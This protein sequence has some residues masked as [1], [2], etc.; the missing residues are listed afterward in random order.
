MDETVTTILDGGMGQEL[1]RRA[2]RPP[3]PLWSSRVLLDEPRL[4][5][6][7]HRDYIDA[8][9]DVITLASYTAT[10]ERLGRD[11]LGELFAP[12]QDA[13]LDAARR[14]R[15]EA[16][17]AG[18]RIA[19]SLPPLVASYRADTTPAHERALASYRA[20][21]ER[22]AEGVDLFLCE[23]MASIAEARAAATAALESGS[24]V[25]VA[26][27]VDDDLSGR[28]RGGEPLAEAVR[29][30]EPLG[31]AA[32]LLNC[33]RPE[34]IEAAWPAL[35]TASVPIGAYANA[36]TSVAALEPGGTVA[37]LQARTDLDP[38]AYAA[39]AARWIEAGASIVGGCCETTPEH[40]RALAALR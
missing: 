34:A 24:P 39:H 13:A 4:V 2:G 1:V 31:I 14:A 5:R 28:L 11:G 16:G 12:L 25:W 26:L 18:V 36:F 27:S 22:Q 38:P 17:R 23:T 35:A 33:S 3:D 10:P 9:A 29:A 19:A 15:D 7:L 6:E 32:L 30:L 20:I 37:A 40:V 8:G 21:V